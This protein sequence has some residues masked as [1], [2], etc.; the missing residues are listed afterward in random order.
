MAKAMASQLKQSSAKPKK[1]AAS[2][3]APASP[4]S[5]ALEAEAAARKKEAREWINR[6]M[7]AK[8][9]AIGDKVQNEVAK[10]LH[11][12]DVVDE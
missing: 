10:K 1:A 9:H 4:S 2:A 11:L 5:A 7:D 6:F 8:K 3:A 12:S